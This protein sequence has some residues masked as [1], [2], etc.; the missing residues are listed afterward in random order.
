MSEG[1]N[2]VVRAL[3]GAWTSIGR[4]LGLPSATIPEPVVEHPPPVATEI[5]LPDGKKARLALIDVKGEYD[6]GPRSSLYKAS[7]G[8]GNAVVRS[9]H[10]LLHFAHSERI[11]YYGKYHCPVARSFQ[12]N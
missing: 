10:Q 7:L 1:P 5:I 12:K 11:T 6:F 3:D 8:V 2:S 9:L 4:F